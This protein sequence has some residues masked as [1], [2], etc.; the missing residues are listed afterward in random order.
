MKYTLIALAV[1][2][3]GLSAADKKIQMKDLPPAVQKTVQA[4]EAKGAKIVGLAT[5]VEGGKTMYEV[6]TT[7][8]GHSRDI[9]VDATGR[10]V[11]T[12][13]ETS[14]S[15]VPAAVRSALEARGTVG[16]VETVTK[17]TTVTYEAVVEKGGKKTEVAVTAAG[18]PIKS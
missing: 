1:A 16:K 13:E 11:E 10:I 17:G 9:L 4:E 18:K 7:V 6:E 14:I 8:S 12:E 3:S 5:E 15:A 2:V